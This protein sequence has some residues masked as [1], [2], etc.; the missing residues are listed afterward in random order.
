[1]LR[2]IDYYRTIQ[3]FSSSVPHIRRHPV[4][5]IA[6]TICL[7]AALFELAS[8]QELSGRQQIDTTSLSNL[9]FQRGEVLRWQSSFLLATKLFD[10]TFTRDF[11]AASLRSAI[12]AD[13]ISYEKTL[14]KEWSLRPLDANDALRSVRIAIGYAEAGGS[15]YL[16]YRALK[17]HG[18]LK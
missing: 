8:A 11:P 16:A 14:G 12:M 9:V 13:P 2:S 17:N 15:L 5:R 4:M 18:F 10:S 6:S 7:V 3:Y 1:M